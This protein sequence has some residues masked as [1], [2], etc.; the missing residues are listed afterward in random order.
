MDTDRK[1]SKFRGKHPQLFVIGERTRTND[2]VRLWQSMGC[3][4]MLRDGHGM[5]SV[6]PRACCDDDDGGAVE[7]A[8]ADDPATGAR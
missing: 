5:L 8:G 7:Q 3:E 1:L 2:L 4:V 6:V